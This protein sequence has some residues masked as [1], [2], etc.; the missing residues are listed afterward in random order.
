MNLG[1]PLIYSSGIRSAV[2]GIVQ[3]LAGPDV[4][5]VRRPTGRLDVVGL[6]ALDGRPTWFLESDHRTD[7]TS[8]FETAL[9]LV[10]FRRRSEDPDAATEG[11]TP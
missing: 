9:A 2:V 7:F 1:D 10:A 8:A 5:I 4:A 6:W 11:G 3:H